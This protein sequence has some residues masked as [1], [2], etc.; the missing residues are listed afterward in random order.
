MFKANFYNLLWIW[1]VAGDEVLLFGNFNKD[2]YSGEL[3]TYISGDEFR[4]K[5]MCFLD[6][7]NNTP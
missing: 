7:R 3:A 6:Y 1:K 2:V 5:E 4:M